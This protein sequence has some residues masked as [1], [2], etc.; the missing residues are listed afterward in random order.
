MA[1][2]RLGALI[3]S[4]LRSAVEQAA[5]EFNANLVISGTGPYQAYLEIDDRK[6][7]DFKEKIDR[8]ACGTIRWSQTVK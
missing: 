7:E 1:I 6:V 5:R 2:V 8:A 4:G 3:Q